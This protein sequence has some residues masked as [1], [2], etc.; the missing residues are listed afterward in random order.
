MIILFYFYKI[1]QQYNLYLWQ[2]SHLKFSCGK[3]FLP[4]LAFFLLI[5]TF[6]IVFSSRYSSLNK[7]KFKFVFSFKICNLFIISLIFQSSK[8]FVFLLQYFWLLSNLSLF[9]WSYCFLLWSIPLST[10]LIVHFH[11]IFCKFQ[12]YL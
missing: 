1:N 3:T 2:S 11:C 12:I 4:C 10:I 6:L 5:Q 9:F 7:F 8:I